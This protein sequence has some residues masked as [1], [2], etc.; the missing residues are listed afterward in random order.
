METT[1]AAMN[2]TDYIIL[3]MF[4]LLVTRERCLAEE[5]E[6]V[7]DGACSAKCNC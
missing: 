2:D 3:L 5:E 4:A 7:A 6:V 1:V